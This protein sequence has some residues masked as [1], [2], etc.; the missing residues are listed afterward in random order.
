M[1]ITLMRNMEFQY[2]KEDHAC[3]ETGHHGGVEGMSIGQDI[4]ANWIRQHSQE[5]MKW[6]PKAVIEEKVSRPCCWWVIGDVVM[7]VTVVQT[8]ERA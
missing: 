4:V 8:E 3:D 5:T 6:D 2:L 7:E 1:A